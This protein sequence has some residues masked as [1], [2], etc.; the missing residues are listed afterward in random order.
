MKRLL[1]LCLFSIAAALHIHAAEG[2][3]PEG[4]V[5]LYLQLNVEENDLVDTSWL[6]G[7]ADIDDYE[8][9]QNGDTKGYL[10]LR[11]VR[12]LDNQSNKI[13]DYADKQFKNTIV[14]RR[15]FIALMY[16]LTGDPLVTYPAEQVERNGGLPVITE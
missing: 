3:A 8:A 10:V 11:K 12:Y 13:T 5:W 6:Y 15:E 7:L 9:L 4:Q 16:E 2:D 14:I 1:L